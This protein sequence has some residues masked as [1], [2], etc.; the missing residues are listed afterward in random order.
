MCAD[1]ITP[2]AADLLPAPEV[3]RV[4]EIPRKQTQKLNTWVDTD[5][6]KRGA[7]FP[8]KRGAQ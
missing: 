2:R 7:Q 6:E 1:N 8:P 5:P 4:G 3:R